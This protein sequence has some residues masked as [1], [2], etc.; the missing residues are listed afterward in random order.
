MRG[1]VGEWVSGLGK[2]MRS[3]AALRRCSRTC[4][5][6]RQIACGHLQAQDQTV[7]HR[8]LRSSTPTSEHLLKSLLYMPCAD[9]E[10]DKKRTPCTAL[11]NSC[12]LLPDAGQLVNCSLL[13]VLGS[14]LPLILQPSTAY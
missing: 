7:Q 14:V 8:L 12:C 4:G 13:L 10:R 2:E 1:G 6:Q 3:S 5:Q 9:K 11:S